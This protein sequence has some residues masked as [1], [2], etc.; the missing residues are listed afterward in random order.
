M[1]TKKKAPKADDPGRPVTVEELTA[2]IT[3]VVDA[4]LKKQA[5]KAEKEAIEEGL[6]DVADGNLFPYDF[7]PTPHCPGCRCASP[8]TVPPGS[9]PPYQFW[10]GRGGCRW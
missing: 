6:Q 3:T 4:Y 1:P 10:C 7:H 8:S 5:E 2:L 9:P